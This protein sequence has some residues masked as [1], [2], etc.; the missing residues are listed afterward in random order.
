MDTTSYS[1][2]YTPTTDDNQD[3]SIEGQPTIDSTLTTYERRTPEKVESIETSVP[4][5]L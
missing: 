3:G 4:S 5:G 1:G 2:S